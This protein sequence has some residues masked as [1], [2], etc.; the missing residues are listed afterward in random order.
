ML[1]VEAEVTEA[2]GLTKAEEN[3]EEAPEKAAGPTASDEES[4]AADD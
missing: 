2:L 1:E 3:V 4:L